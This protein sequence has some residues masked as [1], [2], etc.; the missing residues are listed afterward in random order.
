MLFK[1]INIDDKINPGLKIWSVNSNYVKEAERLFKDGIFKYIEL[2]ALP[3]SYKDYIQYWKGLNIPFVIHAPHSSVGMN[4]AVREM[5]ESNMEMAKETRKFADDLKAEIII[6]HSG[7]AGDTEETARQLKEINENRA[8]IENKPYFGLV[9]D[10]ILNGYSPTEIRHI[11]DFTGSGFCLDMGHAICAANALKIEK[12]QFLEQFLTLK[13]TMFHL[14]DGDIDGIY[15]SHPHFG[16]GSYDLK[17]LLNLMPSNSI[18]S[19][20]TVK[21]SK[22]NLDDFAGD[23]EYLSKILKD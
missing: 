13:P 14:S 23:I 16:G 5:K 8:V 10:V 20:E 12:K 6:F 11:M 19:V 2:F 18:V 4:L 9:D 21:N 17:Y 3:G 22:E 7:A 15:D 1:N